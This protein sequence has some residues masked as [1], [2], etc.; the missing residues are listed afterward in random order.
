M[1]VFPEIQVIVNHH[2]PFHPTPGEQ[3]RRIVRHGMADVLAW[4]GEEVGPAPHEATHVLRLPGALVVSPKIA[5][6]L[7][8]AA[9]AMGA[10][11]NGVKP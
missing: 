7:R 3:A 10:E 8:Q 9:H 4:L 11:F 5:H 1:K 6:L 2:L